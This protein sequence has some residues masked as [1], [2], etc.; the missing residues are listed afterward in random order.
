MFYFS[1]FYFYYEPNMLLSP[2]NFDEYQLMFDH[3]KSLVFLDGEIVDFSKATLSIAN[4]AFLYGLGCFTGM[5]AHYNE[6][7]KKLFVFRPDQHYKRFRFACKLLR[8]KNFLDRYD[9]DKFLNVVKELIKANKI[10][11]D[12]YIRITNYSNENKV[13]PKLIEYNDSLCAYLYPLGD[14]VPTSGMRCK[15]SSWVRASDNSIPARAKINGLYVN[16]AFAKTEALLEGYDEAIFLD[17]RGHVV[18]G[19]AE[20]IFFVFEDELVTPPVTDNILEGITRKSVIQI[21]SDLGI[22]VTERSV[23]RTELYKAD[24]IF[25]TG[26]GAKVSPVIEVDRYPIGDGSVGKISSA[27]QKVYFDT[28]KGDNKKYKD[29]LVEVS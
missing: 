1:S 18:E 5:R 24:E 4:T 17:D 21:A 20:N 27:I 25:L 16:T 19:S 7:S 14:Y 6:E 28:V 12:V 2:D 8:Y 29:W 26:T 22:K 10:N 23:D 11:H 9:Y 3:E 15:V 13:T